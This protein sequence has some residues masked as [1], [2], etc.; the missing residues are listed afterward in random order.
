V[1][2]AVLMSTLSTD[3][4]SS[5]R[6]SQA[7]Y[8]LLRWLLP[9]ASD[10]TLEV[11]HLLIRKSAHVAEYFVFS[12]LLL[13]ALRAPERER[14]SQSQSH[15]QSQWKMRWAVTALLI[16]AMYAGLDEFHQSFVPSRTA[17]GWDALL[18]TVAASAAQLA[19]WMHAR[20][21]GHTAPPAGM[22]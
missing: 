2:W 3:T 16:A 1:A 18:D 9:H 20:R 13:R 22:T 19:A 5:E 10:A 7:V 21:R 15:C 8:P 17:S 12:L 4:F 11:V 14:Q 6:T